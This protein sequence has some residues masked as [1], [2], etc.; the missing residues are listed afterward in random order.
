MSAEFCPDCQQ[1]HE[2]GL[3]ECPPMEEKE[4]WPE[5][6]S[7][8]P[9]SDRDPEYLI[10]KPRRMTLT[11]GVDRWT[12]IYEKHLNE[13]ASETDGIPTL[14]HIKRAEQLADR[15]IRMLYAS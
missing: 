3:W 2:P 13:F 10:P 5:M 9:P 6:Q 11:E 1:L 12:A 15:E 8:L 7:S 14:G 4:K